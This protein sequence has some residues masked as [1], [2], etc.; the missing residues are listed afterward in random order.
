MTH[1]G[2]FITGTDTGV[3]KTV[4]TTTLARLLVLKGIDVGIMKPME[5]G[6]PLIPDNQS[7]AERL[8]AAAEVPEP[9][10]EVSPIRL[11]TPASP[12]QACLLEGVDLDLSVISENFL[13][14]SNRHSLT[15]VEGV[16]GLVVPLTRTQMLTDLIKELNLPLILVSRLSLG[17]LNHTLMTVRI[18]N[19]LGLSIKGIIF[20]QS[21]AGEISKVEAGCP[22]IIKELSGVD[23]LGTLPFRKSPFGPVKLDDTTYSRLIEKLV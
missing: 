17:T 20:N 11:Q 23:I 15:L 18:A 2:F 3:G 10:E 22:E 5:T 6:V 12:Y 13:K 21:Q 9:L 7:D 1:K 14:I 19:Q 8:I 4:V 16:G